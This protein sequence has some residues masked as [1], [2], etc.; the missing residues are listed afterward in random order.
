VIVD[1]DDFKHLY[2]EILHK[3]GLLR[4]KARGCSMSPFVRDGAVITV[5]P[6]EA[7]NV[8]FGDV[9][10]CSSKVGTVV[11]RVVG[12]CLLNKEPAFMIRGD[13]ASSSVE[14]FLATEVLGRVVSVEHRGKTVRLNQGFLRLM[15]L[16][17][18]TSPRLVGLLKKIR[19]IFRVAA[20]IFMPVLQS[21]KL[22]R[23]TAK[24]VIGKR[25]R[26]RTATCQDAFAISR[27]L[28]YW[29]ASEIS[30]PVG[31]AVRKIESA[32]G[33]SH[34]LVATLRE[35]IVGA[36]VIQQFP[37]NVAAGPDW[38]ISEVRVP[39]RYRGVGIGRGL[40]IKA[41]FKA[42]ESGAKRLGGDVASINTKMVHMCEKFSA[43]QMGPQEYSKKFAETPH[44]KPDVHIIF[45]RSIQ[46]G[47]DVL[48][49]EGVLYRYCGTGCLDPS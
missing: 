24:R 33:P 14:T 3:G 37:G 40:I 5:E 6:V 22:Y 45:H 43:Q 34:I 23:R 20:F 21:R 46:A 16:L 49:A 41:G 25:I 7:T 48:Q 2:T 13:Y 35:R 26:Y 15:G 17:W 4:F 8:K 11:H 39:V 27:L 1:P 10:F 12:K 29:T 30:D 47:L 9:V 19:D 44:Y 32:E 42:L 28:G 36:I 38:W 18:A 31:M